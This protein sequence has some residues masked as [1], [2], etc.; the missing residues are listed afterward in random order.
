MDGGS[1]P[2][3]P[4]SESRGPYLSGRGSGSAFR[5]DGGSRP[6]GPQPERLLK[7]TDELRMLYESLQGR[8][9]PEDILREVSR[10]TGVAQPHREHYWWA[11]SGMNVEFDSPKPPLASARR[12]VQLIDLP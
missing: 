4:Y 10:L 3:D 2:P 9:R 8:H 6:S 11:W 5:I 7:M 1:R 12:L